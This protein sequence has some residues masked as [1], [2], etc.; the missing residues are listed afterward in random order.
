[1]DPMSVAPEGLPRP[2]LADRL[3]YRTAESPGWLRGEPSGDPSFEFWLRFKDG[4]RADPLALTFLV[5]S[6]PPA[7]LELGEFA[8]STIELTV[9]VRARPA[10]EWLACRQS[11][12]YV[13]SAYHDEDVEIWDAEGT[14]VAQARQIA[15]LG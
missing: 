2:S 8:S 9:H 10:T 13:V 12:R 14:L 6:S 5:D 4:R 11:T 15:L 1:M 3:E 7:V